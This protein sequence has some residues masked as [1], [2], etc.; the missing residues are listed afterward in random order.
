MDWPSKLIKATRGGPVLAET[1]KLTTPL[2]MPVI[3]NHDWSLVGA[4]G[5]SRFSVGGLT[6]D[7]ESLPPA[8]VSIFGAMSTKANGSSSR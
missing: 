7:N 6:G 8:A 4:K 1:E 2:V 5:G 3:F